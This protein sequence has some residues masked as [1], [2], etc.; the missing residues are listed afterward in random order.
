[1]VYLKSKEIKIKKVK[2]EMNAFFNEM[3]EKSDKKNLVY[4][5]GILDACNNNNFL[6]NFAEELFDLKF[7]LYI[8]ANENEGCARIN[9][10]YVPKYGNSHI[11]SK[12]FF[13][14]I[15]QIL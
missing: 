13:E 12:Y 3:K 6:N 8:K 15:T 14:S 11:K 10:I 5:C 1:M 7:F 4:Y 2:E 9:S